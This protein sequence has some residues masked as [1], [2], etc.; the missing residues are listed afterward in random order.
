MKFKAKLI[1]TLL[2]GTI[3]ALPLT[4]PAFAEPSYGT[5]S[6]YIERVDWWWDNHGHDAN[7]YANYGWHHGSYEYHGHKYAC[8]RA[9]G[10][11][12]QVWQDR[13]SGHPAAANDVAEEAAAARAACYNR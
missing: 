9:R 10:L 11:Q 1:M 13:H 2:G 4:P 8:R 6:N 7:D 3:L 5:N 12:T